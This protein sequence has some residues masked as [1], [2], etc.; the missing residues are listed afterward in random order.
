MPLKNRISKTLILAAAC[1]FPAAAQQPLTTVSTPTFAWVHGTK[2]VYLDYPATKAAVIE[3]DLVSKAKR[4]LLPEAGVSP[5]HV[6][7]GYDGET[8]A[9]VLFTTKPVYPL[10]SIKVNG[11]AK[12]VIDNDGGWKESVWLGGGMVVWIDYRHKTPSD[13][14]GEVYLYDLAAGAGK[15][16]TNNPS[17]QG[18]PATDGSHVVWLDYSAGTKGAV[19]VYDIAKGTTVVASATDSHQDNPRVFGEWVVWEDYRNAKTDTLNADIYAYNITTKEVKVLCDKPGFQ[20]R[21]YLQGTG[22]VWEDYRNASGD[23]SKVDIFGYDLTGKTEY[24]I[25]T[26]NG[27][28][29]SPVNYGNELVWFGTEGSAMN[30]YTAELP[31]KSTSIRSLV[32]GPFLSAVSAGRLFRMDGRKAGRSAAA[33]HDVSGKGMAPLG[34]LEWR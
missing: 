4:T 32:P 22:V 12:K 6:E 16:L 10:E 17:Y 25:T 9:Y 18:K 5:W 29:S 3:I 14:N 7:Y 28:D 20:G 21:P 26:R 31:F 15:R 2:A 24:Q 23:A 33:G 34:Y 11:G 19:T 13:K 8:L 1:T 27:F 30:L